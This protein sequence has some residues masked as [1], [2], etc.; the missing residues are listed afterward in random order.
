MQTLLAHA[1]A[2]PE[3]VQLDLTVTEGNEPA[4]RL[5]ERFGFCSWGVYPGAVLVGGSYLGKVHMTLRL[6]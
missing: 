6:R 2:C 3:L 4:R 1:Q 5:Y